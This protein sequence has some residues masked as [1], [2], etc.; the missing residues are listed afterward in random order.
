MS[1]ES[2][3]LQLGKVLAALTRVRGGGGQGKEGRGTH[4][5]FRSTARQV[6]LKMPITEPAARLSPWSQLDSGH[7]PCGLT[8]PLTPEP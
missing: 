6:R 1:P 4:G 7:V 8:S 5:Y 2:W 3:G